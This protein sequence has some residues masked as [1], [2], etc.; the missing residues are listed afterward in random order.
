M[1]TRAAVQR[2]LEHFI[3]EVAHVQR[4][5]GVRRAIV[6][7]PRAP[8]RAVGADAAARCLP[9]VQL[10]RQPRR[11]RRLALRAAAHGQ[12][13]RSRRGQRQR[14]LQRRGGEDARHSQDDGF[15]TAASS[16]EEEWA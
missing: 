1:N 14:R 10:R 7:R 8:R 4:A 9:A 16:C 5:V 2:V 3:E 15:S 6:Q 13:R 12:A 11:R